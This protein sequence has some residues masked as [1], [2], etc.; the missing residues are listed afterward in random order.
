MAE[1]YD[2]TKIRLD[3]M[4]PWER[5]VEIDRQTKR[6][7]T[8]ISQLGVEVRNTKVV[9]PKPKR[10]WVKPLLITAAVV[11]LVVWLGNKN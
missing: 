8:D 7:V 10:S 2:F 1:I 11:G 3:K 5:I 9:P 6:V 4:T